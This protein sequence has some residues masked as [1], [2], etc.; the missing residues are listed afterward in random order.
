M[1]LIFCV[2]ILVLSYELLS[3][4]KSSKK[5]YQNMTNKAFLNLINNII[6]VNMITI[7]SILTIL[8]TE[9]QRPLQMFHSIQYLFSILCPIAPWF[10]YE[11]KNMYTVLTYVKEICTIYKFLLIGLLLL[12]ILNIHYGTFIVIMSTFLLVIFR[13][14]AEH[15]NNTEIYKYLM[16]WALSLMCYYT[17]MYIILLIVQLYIDSCIA[18]N[19]VVYIILIIL[20]FVNVDVC[21]TFYKKIL[22]N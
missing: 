18:C 8:F 2:I 9:D 7:S 16:L 15:Y 11:F 3:Y 21:K 12:L 5:E 19:C 10:I 13:Y 1:I 17:L 22:L 20:I 4:I 14:T 6:I